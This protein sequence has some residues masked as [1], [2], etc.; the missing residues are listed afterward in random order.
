LEE[1]ETQESLA[2]Q[3]RRKGSPSTSRSYRTTTVSNKESNEGRSNS[4]TL[5]IVDKIEYDIV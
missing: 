2:A 5:I 4:N 3:T 1:E